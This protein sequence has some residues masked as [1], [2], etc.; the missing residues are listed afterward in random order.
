MPTLPAPVTK[1]STRLLISD[2]IFATILN[3]R[4]MEI[5]FPTPFSVMRSPSH[6]KNAE[7]AVKETVITTM[8]VK[9]LPLLNTPFVLLKPIVMATD[10]IMA[11][12][13]VRYLE[14]SAIFFLPSSPSFWSSSSLGMAMV[15]SCIIMEEVIYGEMFNAKMDIS[16]KEPP[17]NASRKPKLSPIVESSQSWK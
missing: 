3:K 12:P 10:S 7:P 1:R 17:V 4:I 16:V 2:G 9:R 6:I 11:S 14:I 5:P 15:R 8:L 13:I